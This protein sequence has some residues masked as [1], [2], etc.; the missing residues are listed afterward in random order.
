MYV[1]LFDLGDAERVA[2]ELSGSA[3]QAKPRQIH[4]AYRQIGFLMHEAEVQLFKSRGRRGGGSWAQLADST[5]ERKGNSRILF[6][7]GSRPGYGSGKDALYRSLTGFRRKYSVFSYQGYDLEFGTTRP[8]AEKHMTGRTKSK[9]PARPFIK[10]TPYDIGKW[11][12]VMVQHLI[13]PF[14]IRA[15]KKRIGRMF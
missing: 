3:F 7:T 14:K 4:K 11:K 6:T 5:V 2:S 13:E 15:G 1:E 8:W 9:M 10:F 12:V